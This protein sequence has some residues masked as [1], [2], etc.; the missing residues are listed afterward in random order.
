ML[1]L[2]ATALILINLYT[3]WLDPVRERLSSF[4]APFYW[5]TG[6]PSRVGDWAGEQLRTREEL[7]EENSRLQHQVMLLEQ[8][9]QLLAAVRA[10]NTQL[11]ELMNSAE[12]VDQRVLV[13][14]VIGVSPDPL[15]HV[16][17]IDKGRSDG[18]RQ[19]AAIMDASGLLGQVI[20]AGDF[21]S[22]VLLITDANHAL[23]VQVLR[24][25]VRAVA[26]G[27]GDLYRLEL[28]HL[29]NTSDIREGDL[30]L[31]SGLG[32]RFPAGYPVGEVIS[33]RRDPGR[34]F[35]DVDVLPRGRM[36][37]SRFVLAV[38]D[39]E[40]SGLMDGLESELESEPVPEPQ[41]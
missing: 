8:Q 13:A 22:R 33:V 35:A 11:K 24:N 19:G 23:P 26:E 39:D 5:I 41:D 17:I 15:E 18:V 14:Q 25:S 9:T 20:E 28:R 21:S 1:G 7:L 10:E 29:A 37:R 12:T 2:A 16:V 40:H 38:I 30:L 34:A 31:S 36:N 6:T 27:T 3:D 4:A 32:G